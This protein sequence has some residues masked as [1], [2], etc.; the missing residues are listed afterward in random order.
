MSKYYRRNNY[1]NPFIQW[2]LNQTN[3]FLLKIVYYI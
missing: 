2:F 1:K 3:I